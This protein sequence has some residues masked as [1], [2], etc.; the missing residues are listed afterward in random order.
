MIV[1]A[2]L[3]HNHALRNTPLGEINACYRWV[4]DSPSVPWRTVQGGAPKLVNSTY[5]M[6]GKSW[7]EHD[8][9]AV[10]V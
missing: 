5:N 3:P 8:I 6:L 9:W 10:K 1:L 7:T 2:D 4:G